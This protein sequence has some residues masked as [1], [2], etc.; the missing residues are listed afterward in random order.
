M[1]ITRIIIELIE[2]I[3]FCS[4]IDEMLSALAENI[5]LYDSQ[6]SPVER[7]YLYVRMQKHLKYN[8]KDKKKTVMAFH[9]LNM[10]SESRHVYY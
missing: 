7:G 10:K 2:N 9:S 4:Q 5:S 6:L 8:T 1:I 3:S